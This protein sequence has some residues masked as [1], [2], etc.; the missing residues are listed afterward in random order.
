MKGALRNFVI[1]LLNLLKV[2]KL[3][4]LLLA[5]QNQR[6][7]LKR[8]TASDGVKFGAHAIVHNKIKNKIK[9]GEHTIV[10]GELLVHD[11]G[12]EIDIG[13]YCYI[14]LGARVWSGENVKIGNH[15]FLAHN[16]N[17]TDTNSHQFDAQERKE[18]FIK[19]C[20]NNMP[21]EKG[22]IKT[23]PVIIGDH[24]WINF[25]VGILKGVKIGEGAVVGAMSLV[26]KDVPSYTLVAGNP[27]VV[28]RSLN[29]T[30]QNIGSPNL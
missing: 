20:V 23:S 11:Y 25:G 15:V 7:C 9:I 18:H 24:A 6:E 1:S 3:I 12:G 19:R 28:I 2:G 17:I 21:F 14:G 13:S 30:N 5:D 4:N 27:A 16:V 22:S 10:D 29:N 8:V 26:T